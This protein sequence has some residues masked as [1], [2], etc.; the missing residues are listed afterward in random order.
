ME[1]LSKEIHLKEAVKF[2]KDNLQ[3]IDRVGEWYVI[4]TIEL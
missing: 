2:L 3:T 4:F 1:K